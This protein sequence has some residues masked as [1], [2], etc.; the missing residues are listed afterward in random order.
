MNTNNRAVQN[1][2]HWIL[3]R[4]LM[5]LQENL[6][7]YLSFGWF[8]FPLTTTKTTTTAKQAVVKTIQQKGAVRQNIG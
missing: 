1:M 2:V 3:S 6:E 4:E 5:L 8:V 7:R